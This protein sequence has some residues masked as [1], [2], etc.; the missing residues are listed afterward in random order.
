M[1]LPTTESVRRRFCG[2]G[3]VCRVV[4]LAVVLAVALGAAL[5]TPNPATAKT[6]YRYSCNG[7]PGTY[8]AAAFWAAAPDGTSA[9]YKVVLECGVPGPYGWGIN[10][11]VAPDYSYDDEPLRQHFGGYLSDWEAYAFAKALQNQPLIQSNGN[12]LYLDDAPIYDEQGDYLGDQEFS[13][14]VDPSTFPATIKTAWGDPEDIRSI[15]GTYYKLTG[16][17]R[18]ADFYQLV[19][20]G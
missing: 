17:N 19:L 20:N 4:S 10:H 12:Q 14:V 3:T 13:V 6:E 11:I 1:G 15:T 2:R 5:V 7:R 18:P 8:V 9:P 16:W